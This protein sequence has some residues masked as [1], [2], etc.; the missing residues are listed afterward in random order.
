MKN[1]MLVTLLFAIVLVPF[2][3]IWALN[4]LFDLGILYTWQTWLAMFIVNLFFY[5][6]TQGGRVK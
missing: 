2:A 3:H 1:V 6:T 5:S 4:T